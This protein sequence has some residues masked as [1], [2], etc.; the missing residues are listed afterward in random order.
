MIFFFKDFVHLFKDKIFCN[1][2]III[3]SNQIKII[4]LNVFYFK[5]VP[6]LLR[7]KVFRRA[8][9][10]F[11]KY[12]MLT[13]LTLKKKIHFFYIEIEEQLIIFILNKMLFEYPPMWVCWKNIIKQTRNLGC[14][15]THI[16]PLVL[17]GL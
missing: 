3:Y 6:K 17:S 2:F 8:M 7:S 13:A 15:V 14:Y 16:A 11:Y 1:F 12:C 9:K 10:M 4:F 5:I